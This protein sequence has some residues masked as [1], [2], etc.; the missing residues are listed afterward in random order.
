MESYSI[1][2]RPD[3]KPKAVPA[4]AVVVEDFESRRL[5]AERELD[6]ILQSLAE[7][8]RYITNA[9]GVAIALADGESDEML[10]RAAS[11]P[12]AP[13]A[14]TRL[15][16]RSGLTGEAVHSDQPLRCDDT[17]T[18]ERVNRDSCEALGVASVLVMRVADAG[19]VTGIV[20]L[21]SERKFAF[22]DR[23]NLALKSVARAIESA[24][25]ESARLGVNLG[26]I[27]WA[28]GKEEEPDASCVA[29]EVV[30]AETVVVE[31]ELPEARPLPPF[32]ARLADEAE[33]A[34]SRNWSQW[35]RP[36]W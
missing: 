21:F 11:G 22:G 12:L 17:S 10:C 25:T 15:Q 32:L 6:G 18:D 28:P 27:P 9:S 20:E 13:P 14:G 35:F 2:Q 4:Q 31:M 29:P 19:G 3:P 16:I 33:A 23:E 5:R 7:R 8:A 1:L 36:Q 30:P 24:L 34:G 26:R